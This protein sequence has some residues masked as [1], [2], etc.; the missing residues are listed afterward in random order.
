M[1]SIEAFQELVKTVVGTIAN[2]PLDASLQDELNREFPYEGEL[3]QKLALACKQGMA[4]GWMGQYEH[5]GLRYGRVIK[6]SPELAGYSVDVV[7]MNDMAGPHH[8]HPNGEIDF[9]M[10]L[11][12]Q[13]QFDGQSAGWLVYGPGTSHSPTVRRGRALVLYLLPEGKIEFTKN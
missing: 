1:S 7:D 11:D 10:P 12:E 3:C 2:R 8:S 13:A 4:D 5:K 9:I 6:P